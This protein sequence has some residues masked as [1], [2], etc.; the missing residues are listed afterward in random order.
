MNTNR[1][2]PAITQRVR[3]D[4]IRKVVLAFCVFIIIVTLAP[5]AIG[6][7]AW[8]HKNIHARYGHSTVFDPVSNR[9][10]IL[11]GQH[12]KN[13][14]DDFDLWFAVYTPGSTDLQM[15]P[16][17]L[18]TGHPSARFG[19]T[20]VFD[21]TNNRMVIF[22]G[23]TGTSTPGP[24][25]N[26]VWLLQNAN[27]VSATPAWTQQHP[28]GTVPGARFAPTAVYDATTNTMILF[29]GYDCTANYLNDVWILNNANGLG[30]TPTWT[31]LSVSGTVPSGREAATAVYDPTNN[32]MTVYGGDVGTAVDGDVWVLSHANG[33]GG[34][35]AW[36]QLAPTGPAPVARSG[37]SAIYDAANNRMTIYAGQT[38]NSVTNLLNDFWVL[39]NANGI[40]GAPAWTQLTPQ[41]P[42]AFR[43]FHTA[44]YDAAVN[45]MLIFGGKTSVSLLPADDHV[46]VVTE[47]NGLLP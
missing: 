2:L 32:V 43:S 8:K 15:I 40:G 17:T 45:T 35:P 7:G 44:V 16:A 12:A 42:G 31:Q 10:I 18:A 13:F 6:Q 5:L 1:E 30:G 20:A 29:G 19:H 25:L 38:S 22:G 33:M 46:T 14:P 4:S 11:A 28:A 21:S 47:A 39:T 3:H 37:H 27:G 36:T 9:M 34:T 24:C 26:D 41:T 23:G